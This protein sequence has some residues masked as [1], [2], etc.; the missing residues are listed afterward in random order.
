MA[1]E[2]TPRR[3]IP[4]W[5]QTLGHVPAGEDEPGWAFYLQDPTTGLAYG[6]D[7]DLP[8]WCFGTGSGDTFARAALDHLHPLAT[9]E[10][11]HVSLALDI[12]RAMGLVY[13][14]DAQTIR[15]LDLVGLS[16]DAKVTPQFC[17]P[18]PK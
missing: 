3:P 18:T 5:A 11:A 17:L 2:Q 16:F 7:I 10:P 9:A 6:F 1:P 8:C 4:K 14:L 15:V 12:L 13:A